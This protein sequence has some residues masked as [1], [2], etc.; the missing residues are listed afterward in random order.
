MSVRSTHFQ[1]EVDNLAYNMS[2]LREEESILSVTRAALIPKLTCIGCKGFYRGPTRICP[3]GHGICSICL[4]G[5]DKTVCPVEECD[6]EAVVSLDFFGD[7]VK[8]RFINDVNREGGGGSLLQK[9]VII[10]NTN[11][12]IILGRLRECDIDKGGDVLKYQK[13]C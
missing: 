12:K 4:P 1:T 9:K 7:L 6:K 11:N 5:G 3:N 13:F 2:D 8:G 10:G